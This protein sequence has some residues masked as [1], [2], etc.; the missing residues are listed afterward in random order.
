MSCEKFNFPGENSLH[1]ITQC[2]Y[3][4]DSRLV[5]IDKIKAFIP[6]IHL[7]PKKRLYEIL[8]PGY[9]KHNADLSFYNT[10]IMIANQNFIYDSKVFL[11]K[12]EPFSSSTTSPSSYSS[13]WSSFSSPWSFTK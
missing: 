4:S 7:L 13:I 8:V 3:Y 1:Y 5:I 12:K 11:F 9:D 2:D 6:N 10:K